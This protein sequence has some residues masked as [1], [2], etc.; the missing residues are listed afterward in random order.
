MWMG[1]EEIDRQ[2]SDVEKTG[3]GRE[4]KVQPR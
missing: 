1:A 2:K 3:E 4:T